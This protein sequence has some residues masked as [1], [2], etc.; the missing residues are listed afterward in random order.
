MRSLYTQTRSFLARL[1]RA[2]RLARRWKG[3]R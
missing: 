2:R 1:S 3:A